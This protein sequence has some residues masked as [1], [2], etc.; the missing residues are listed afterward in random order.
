M[1][2]LI[3]HFVR[4]HY[5]KLPIAL[6]GL[7]IPSGAS[8]DSR[9]RGPTPLQRGQKPLSLVGRDYPRHIG[10][11]SPSPPSL[12]AD[13]TSEA[14]N[15]TMFKLASMILE[16]L[17]PKQGL[18]HFRIQFIACTILIVAI[19]HGTGLGIGSEAPG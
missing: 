19:F 10:T 1:K 17:L 6:I 16:G 5:K 8:L 9:A 4:L 18:A 14:G 7:K 3:R 12:K 2:R 15:V 13:G 11:V